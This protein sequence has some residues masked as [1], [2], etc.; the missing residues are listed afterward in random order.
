MPWSRWKELGLPVITPH[1]PWNG[2]S[3]GDRNGL[4]EQFARDAVAGA[5]EKY[6][7]ETWMRRRGALRPE[8]PVR[9]DEGADHTA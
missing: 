7:D 2:Y 3:L 9:T 5:S 1:S 6:G 8:T 4:W